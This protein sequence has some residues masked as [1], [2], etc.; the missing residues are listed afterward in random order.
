M[1][2]DSFHPIQVDYTPDGRD[3][4][5]FRPRLESSVIYYFCHLRQAIHFDNNTTSEFG[6]TP[7][8]DILK[9]GIMLRKLHEQVRK[10]ISTM[11]TTAF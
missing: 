9:F 3:P 2:P 11:T 4:I 8:G 5:K 10:I 6:P 1:C 7:E